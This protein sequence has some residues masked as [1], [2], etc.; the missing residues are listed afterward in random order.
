[1]PRAGDAT[2]LASFLER[3]RTSGE[4]ASRLAN[5]ALRAIRNHLGMDVAFISEL[6][7]TE[8]V[9]RYVDADD[10][11]CPVEVGGAGPLGGQLLP[12]RR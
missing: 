4:S 12:A 8:R 3:G 11:D 1:M 7:S 9:F 6:T 10:A 2:A 5:E